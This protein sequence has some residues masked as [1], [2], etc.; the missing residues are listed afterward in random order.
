MRIVKNVRQGRLDCVRISDLKLNFQCRDEMI[1]ILR[2]LQHLYALKEVRE[3]ILNMIAKDV[4]KGSRADRGRKGFSYWQILVLAVM[5]FGGRMNYDKLQYHAE[6][7]KNLRTMLQVGDWDSTSFDWR[8]IQDNL[9]L[10]RPETVD[11]INHAVVGEG[12]RLVPEAP[13]KLRADSFVGETNIHYPTES[14][15]MRDGVRK[16]LCHCKD[17]SDIAGITGWRQSD[18]LYR[19]AKNLCRRIH[20]IAAAKGRRWEQRIKAPYRELI[21]HTLMIVKRAESSLNELNRIEAFGGIN[22]ETEKEMIGYFLE[23]TVQ[24]CDTAQRRVLKGEIVPNAEKLFSMFETHTQ[25]YK[26]GKAGKPIQYGR[27]IMVYEDT[28]GFIVHHCILGREQ[29]EVAVVVEQTRLLQERLNWVIKY[30]S[31]DRGFH[32]SE[33]QEQLGELVNH[34]CLPMKG[35]KKYS[36]QKKCASVEFRESR[37]RHPGIESAIGALQHGNG[38]DRCPDRTERGFERY[39]AYGILARNIQVLGKLLISRESPDSKASISKRKAA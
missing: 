11:E 4:N 6:S 22:L 37:K 2:G 10:L 21:H 3:P 16:I 28:V 29:Q 14:S 34:L 17:L 32:S 39:V 19:K 35:A 30:L 1:P 5:R 27:M 24:V 33:N 31:L 7:D 12:H 23:L 25:L 36:K 18:H 15:L 26:R 38:L 9:C 13:E 8:R 20:G